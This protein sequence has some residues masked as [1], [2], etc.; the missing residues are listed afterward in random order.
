MAIMPKAAE[1]C[2][3][4]IDYVERSIPPRSPRD[5]TSFIRFRQAMKLR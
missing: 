3:R 5:T 1:V 4:K 2:S